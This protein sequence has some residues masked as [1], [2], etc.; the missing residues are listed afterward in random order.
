MSDLFRRPLE[1]EYRFFHIATMP[2]M[3]RKFRDVLVNLFLVDNLNCGSN[4]LL[5][6]FRRLSKRTEPYATSWVSACLK[7]YSKSPTAGCS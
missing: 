1:T 6:G 5:E 7:E 2:V 4:A 3:V